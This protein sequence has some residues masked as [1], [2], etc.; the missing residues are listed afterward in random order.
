MTQVLSERAAQR[1]GDQ[2][3]A[4]ETRMW[5]VIGTWLSVA[6]GAFAACTHAG[7]PLS[8]GVAVSIACL[9]PGGVAFIIG[10]SVPSLPMRTWLHGANGD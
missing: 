6:I 7:A 2:L 3:L 1:A 9:A 10:M 5:L 8:A 4:N